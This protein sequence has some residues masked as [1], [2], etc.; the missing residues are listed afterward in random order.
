MVPGA[1]LEL[2]A[3]QGVAVQLGVV[4]GPRRGRPVAASGGLLVARGLAAVP[5][6]GVG[7]YA[8][9]ICTL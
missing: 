4:A 1:G 9:P 2:L 5:A 8:I 3:D 7:K 6:V